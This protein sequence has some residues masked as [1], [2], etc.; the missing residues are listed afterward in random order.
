MTTPTFIVSMPSTGSEP[1]PAR[2]RNQ[3]AR[4]CNRCRVH[5]L[6]CDSEYP[7][8]NCRKKGGQCNNDRLNKS[9]TLPQAYREI[10]RLKQR[11][12][13][14]ESEL[15][16]ERRDRTSIRRLVTPSPEQSPADSA[17]EL[18][19]EGK[20][21]VWEGIYISTTR[22][23]N[24]TWYGPASLFFF[25]GRI[26]T[27]LTTALKQAHSARGM[28]PDS[29]SSALLEL[30]APQAA[31]LDADHPERMATPADDPS[32]A[33]ESL[34]SMQ[35]EYFLHLFWESYYPSYPVLDERDFKE[36]YQSLWAT[37]DKER[38]P[39]P[40]VDIVLALC[41]QYGMA[42]QASARLVAARQGHNAPTQGDAPYKDSGV[43]GRWHYRRCLS[44]LATELES[45]TL[46]TL[47]CHLLCSIYLCC[48]GFLNMSENA[49]ALAVRTAFMLGLHV[50]P[51]SDMPRRERELRKRLWWTLFALESNR[52]MKLGR[53]FTLQENAT[54]CT[55]PAD[56][57]EIAGMS[58]SS[59]API[60][61]NVTWLTWNLHKIK[62]MLAARKAY[63]T[64][65]T[66]A[67]NTLTMT[68]AEP[69]TKTFDAW[70][71]NV[72]EVLK[73]SRQNNGVPFSTDR[74]PLRIEQFTPVWLQRERLLLELLYHHLCLS[75]Y[76][77]SICFAL[78]GVPFTITEHAATKSA[79][80]AMALVHIMHQVMNTTTL[81]NGW[82]EAFQ[83]HWNAAM[84]LVGFVLAFP[85][86][87]FACAAR[88]SITLSV[89]AFE[90]SGACFLVAKNAARIMRDLGDKID[91]VIVGEMATSGGVTQNPL[92]PESARTAA[93]VGHPGLESALNTGIG[94][95]VT[96]W[97]IDFGGEPLTAEIG[98]V[99][100]H[101]IDVSAEM[102]DIDWSYLNGSFFDQWAF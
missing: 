52:S 35:E 99:L 85:H 28:V 18:H 71:Q 90:Q 39:S 83:W 13:E 33:C 76:R 42:Q 25:I 87:P 48:A 45:P 75:L 64:I 51:P 56:D 54:S 59:F 7:C 66:K 68:H 69:I 46:S 11:V 92:T 5:R 10:E 100:G 19:E 29:A 102:L 27:F 38:K 50:E 94:D 40:L 41:M 77:S 23:P 88:N 78:R 80:H 14:L 16:N 72:P 96:E 86:S 34:S 30:D 3:V 55:L 63:L 47:Q 49:C 98:G 81:L 9:V 2:K 15:Q 82:H 1:L 31:T 65:F 43:P 4:A 62:L 67:P 70:L 58:G 17:V 37:S 26:N 79:A 74:S 60:G 93:S 20:D 24:K 95:Q 12:E 8:G 84:T 97:P 22:S 61:G 21:K 73:T 91:R 44:L 36:H 6:K 101:S 53:P 57:R 89:S 32:A